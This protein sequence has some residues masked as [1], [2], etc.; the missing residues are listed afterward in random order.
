M[1]MLRDKLIRG[2]QIRR[3]SVSTQKHYVRAVRDLAIYYKRSPEKISC[4]E[5]QR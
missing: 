2:I 4:E 3:L 1:S 5:V